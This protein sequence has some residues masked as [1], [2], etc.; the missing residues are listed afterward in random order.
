MKNFSNDFYQREGIIC[1]NCHKQ[2]NKTHGYSVLCFDC[3]LNF[4]ASGCCDIKCEK[5][6]RGVNK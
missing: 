2:L 4:L 5:M 1:S 3:F 6:G